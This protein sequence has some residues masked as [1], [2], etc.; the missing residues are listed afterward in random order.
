[1]PT[2]KSG[3]AADK[4][5]RGNWHDKLF[6]DLLGDDSG[7]N[8]QVAPGQSI[9]SARAYGGYE[10]EVGCKC[11]NTEPICLQPGDGDSCLVC[12]TDTPCNA[13]A[14]VEMS[15]SFFKITSVDLRSS[16]LQFSAWLR[17]IWTDPRL[18]Y[19]YQCYGASNLPLLQ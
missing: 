3:V 19:D 13:D 5:T 14:R 2:C 8:F 12:E 4:C 7:Y 17:Q 9:I 1:M 18:S 10:E 6:E 15:I 16:E 11:K